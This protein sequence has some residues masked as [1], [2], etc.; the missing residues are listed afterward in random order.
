MTLDQFAALART[1]RSLQREFFRTKAADRRPSLIREAKRAE[2]AFDA[3][4]E[5]LA[6]RQHT[7]FDQKEDR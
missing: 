4:L 5:Q 7:L 2:A 6:V 3:A 1:M